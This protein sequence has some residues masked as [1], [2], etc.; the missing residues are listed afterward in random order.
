L[1][2]AVRGVDSESGVEPLQAVGLFYD[3]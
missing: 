1:V 3:L 2:Y